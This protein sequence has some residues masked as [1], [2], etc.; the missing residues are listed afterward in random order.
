MKEV[1]FRF[2]KYT[3]SLICLLFRVVYHSRMPISFCNG[4]VVFGEYPHDCC[5]SKVEILTAYYLERKGRWENEISTYLLN[6][7]ITACQW[8]MEEDREWKRTH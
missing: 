1:G 8:E 5:F 4:Y 7:Y 3:R 2:P 6:L